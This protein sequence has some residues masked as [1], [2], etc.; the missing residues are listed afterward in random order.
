MLKKFKL[1]C[2]ECGDPAEIRYNPDPD[3]EGEAWASCFKCNVF[4]RVDEAVRRV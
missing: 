4:E 1:T 3:P 2:Q